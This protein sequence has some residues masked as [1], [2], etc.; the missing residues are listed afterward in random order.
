M[1]Q[2]IN[3]SVNYYSEDSKKRQLE[4][5]E[6][7]K[8]V[9][10]PGVKL[11]IADHSELNLLSIEINYDTY[12]VKRAK[13]RNAGAKRKYVEYYPDPLNRGSREHFTYKKYFELSKTMSDI[14][15]IEHLN[16][17]KAT[18]YRRKKKMLEDIEFMKETEENYDAS[19]DIASF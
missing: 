11:T 7:L 6:K 4:E 15:I 17:N 18:F 8:E 1:K 19:Q 12:G 14:E 3:F 16:I 9:L 13:S 5:V 2:F 10:L